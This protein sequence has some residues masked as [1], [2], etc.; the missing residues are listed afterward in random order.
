M[1]RTLALLLA[2]VCC[3]L[4]CLLPLL[5]G[6][7][8]RR[9]GLGLTGGDP[10]RPSLIGSV[11]P[12]LNQVTEC[13]LEWSVTPSVV[14]LSVGRL[15]VFHCR[16]L[17]GCDCL[18]CYYCLRRSGL[19]D[20]QTRVLGTTLRSVTPLP[21]LALARVASPLRCNSSLWLSMK[22]L[23]ASTLAAMAANSSG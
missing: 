11:E 16:S 15:L 10:H 3:C 5:N 9:F 18:T 20:G 8:S 13:R 21:A 19:K 22:A 12:S 23:I 14:R 1:I 4:C 7:D 17:K 6:D 2:S